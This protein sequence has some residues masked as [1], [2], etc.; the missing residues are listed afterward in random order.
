VPLIPK[1][2]SQASLFVTAPS[3]QYG[4]DELTDVHAIEQFVHVLLEWL[5]P[6]FRYAHDVAPLAA[7][8]SQVSPASGLPSPQ[9]FGVP[10]IVPLHVELQIVQLVW[11]YGHTVVPLTP[12]PSSQ[13]SLFVIA[14]SPQNGPVVDAFAQV[15]VHT[16][17]LFDAWLAPPVYVHDVAPLAAPLSQPSPWPAS[18]TPSPQKLTVPAMF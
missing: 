5:V 10:E 6:P 13:T 18:G 2:S 16:E 14:P 11:P 17:Q 4:P 15:D 8:A 3:P 7:P 12:N 9:K 1:P